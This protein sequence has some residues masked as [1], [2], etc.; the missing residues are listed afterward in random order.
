VRE[1]PA[2]GADQSD[3]TRGDKCPR[4]K[5]ARSFFS[6]DELVRA[7]HGAAVA[8][9]AAGEPGQRA[10]AVVHQHADRAGLG[11]DLARR[12]IEMLRAKRID[13]V[14]RHGFRVARP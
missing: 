3:V 5:S 14:G 7:D 1:R 8:A 4:V 12:K 9:L 2:V 11:H 6:G 13:A 10:F